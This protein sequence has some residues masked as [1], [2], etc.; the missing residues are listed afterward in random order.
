M[1]ETTPAGPSGAMHPGPLG[2][3]AERRGLRA[4]SAASRRRVTFAF[5][6]ALFAGPVFGQE[7]SEP[8]TGAASL[9]ES[10]LAAEGIQIDL[11]AG[12][13]GLPVTVLVRDDLLEY[14]VVG[15]R[16]ATHE[17]LFLTQA[18]PSL[19][20]T[21][22]LAIGTEAGE[23]ARWIEKDPGAGSGATPTNDRGHVSPEFEVVPPS[24]SDA[25]RLYLYAGWREDGESYFY[26]VDDLVANLE[27]GRS[28]RRHP[29]VYLGSRFHRVREGE[30]EVFVADLE[31]NLVNV[32]FF[33]QGNT[34]ITAALP[35]C[36]TQTIW[37]ANSW[38][39]P[40]RGSPVT[41][42]FSRSPMSALPAG[43]ESVVTAAASPEDPGAGD[44]EDDAR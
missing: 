26:R 1:H 13:V 31:Q 40:E 32:S 39:L 23:N 34:L 28:M 3:P 10:T 42:V 21:A 15:P 8:E 14:L 9:L 6:L 41:L 35:E 36:Q 38:L 22:L 37:L 18:T 27:T 7:A 20:S 29:W 19:I 24:G 12:R 16:G 30:P 2:P 43:W 25:A 17:G 11:E 5:G 4:M 33:Y 44:S